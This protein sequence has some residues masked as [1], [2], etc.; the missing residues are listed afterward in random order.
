[1]NRI[2]RLHRSAIACGVIALA[3]LTFIVPATQSYFTG[4]AGYMWALLAAMLMTTAIGCFFVW[5]ADK[6]R[7]RTEA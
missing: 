5:A 2:Q 3:M 6:V 1:M 7:A 4:D